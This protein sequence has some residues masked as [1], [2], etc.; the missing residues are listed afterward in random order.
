MERVKVM[1]LAV[2]AV[3]L[4]AQVLG[5]WMPVAH[6]QSRDVVCNAWYQEV[7][8]TGTG[9]KGQAKALEQSMDHV[10]PIRAWLLEHPGDP[11]FRTTVSRAGGTAFVDIMCVR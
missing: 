2:I 6:A 7:L 3:A 11:V 8:V 9:E 4:C 10:G 1:L 5:D